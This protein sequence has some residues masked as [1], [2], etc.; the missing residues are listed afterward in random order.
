MCNVECAQV[1]DLGGNAIL[2]CCSYDA[3]RLSC[4]GCAVHQ[5]FSDVK[6]LTF[7]PHLPSVNV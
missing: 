5:N 6:Y 7:S 4:E 1:D 3:W 2:S